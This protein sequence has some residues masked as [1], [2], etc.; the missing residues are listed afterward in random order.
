MVKSAETLEQFS[1]SLKHS[2]APTGLLPAFPYPFDDCVKRGKALFRSPVVDPGIAFEKAF[3]LH[4]GHS[5]VSHET[6]GK[7]HMVELAVGAGQF[8]D[9]CYAGFS[10]CL[11]S[12]QDIG[13][14]L[15]H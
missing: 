5:D 1:V 10:G 4:E 13:N 2:L 15:M 12:Y 3:P 9:V 14:I 8:A 11:I 7:A 6:E